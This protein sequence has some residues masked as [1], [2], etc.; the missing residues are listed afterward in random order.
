MSFKFSGRKLFLLCSRRGEEHSNTSIFKIRWGRGRAQDYHSCRKSAP[1]YSMHLTDWLIDWLALTLLLDLSC[2]IG[3]NGVFRYNVDKL[4]TKVL[5]GSHGFIAQ[6]NTKRAQERRPPESF[7]KMTE[8]FDANKFNFTRIKQ[9]EMLFE[10]KGPPAATAKNDKDFIVANVSPLEFCHVLLVPKLYSCQPQIL[11]ADSLRLAMHAILLSGTWKLRVG[12][13]SIGAAASVNHLHLHAYYLSHN[14]PTETLP[15]EPFVGPCHLVQKYP[16]S[17][18]VF[19]FPPL[20]RTAETLIEELECFVRDVYAFVDRLQ[21]SDIPHNIFM[22]RGTPLY[23]QVSRNHLVIRVYVWTRD[24]AYELKD[25]T[26]FNVALAELSGH[27]PVKTDEGYRNIREEDVGKVL[28][29]ISVPIDFSFLCSI[30]W[31][32]D[33]TWFSGIWSFSFISTGDVTQE[34]FLRAKPI[35]QKIFKWVGA[36]ISILEILLFCTFSDFFL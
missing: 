2:S 13:N 18:F 12:F 36:F 24:F 9:E 15:A 25:T 19:Q 17:G 34:M 8:I 31:L 3:D 14:L 20:R 16:A 35:A 11:T 22:T 6:L 29:M 28:G 10:M 1:V 7:V 30:D 23:A 32:I 4:D 26:A 21:Q 5:Q 33:W 27:L